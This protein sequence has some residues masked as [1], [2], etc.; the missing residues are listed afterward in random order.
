M[1]L[2]LVLAACTTTEDS[3]KEEVA[4]PTLSWVDPTDGGTVIAGDNTCSVAV[5]EF[6]LEEPAKHSDGEAAGYLAVYVDGAEALQTGSTSFSLTLAA[7]THELAAHLLYEDGDEVTA[8]AD[9]LCG[10]ETTD[11]ACEPV[12]A[13]IMVTAS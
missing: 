13:V 11:T 6:M 5:S 3:A 7:G 1:L 4:P 12:L 10:E 9:H 8:T 2:A